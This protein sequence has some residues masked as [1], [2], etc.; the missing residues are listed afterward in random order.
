M[1]NSLCSVCSYGCAKQITHCLGSGWWRKIR[2][3]RQ[4]IPI[5]SAN[6]ATVGVKTGCFLI[7]DMLYHR[8]TWHTLA[9]AIPL[10]LDK[11]LIIL[12]RYGVQAAVHSEVLDVLNEHF[13]TCMEC[14]ASPL[15][16]R[17]PR[18]C[19]LFIDTDAPFGSL[20]SFFEFQPSRGSFEANPPFDKDCVTRMAAHMLKLLLQTDVCPS[21]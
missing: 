20:G 4:T 18:F 17:W 5:D 2:P 8:C 21:S 14:F 3:S 10:L 15:N 7:P 9:S 11:I 16:C 12:Q 6:I 19:S 1:H 13:G